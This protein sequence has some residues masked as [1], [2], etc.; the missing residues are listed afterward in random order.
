LKL[1]RLEQSAKARLDGEV[2][3]VPPQ[4]A[5][6]AVGARVEGQGL[7]FTPSR[8]RQGER[9]KQ[10]STRVTRHAFALWLGRRAGRQAGRQACMSHFQDLLSSPFDSFISTSCTVQYC[11]PV[12]YWTVPSS[13][14]PPPSSLPSPTQHHSLIVLS[15]ACIGFSLV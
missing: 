4:E 9:P 15:Q 5:H 1:A 13:L 11:T 14:L 3:A 2:V 12:P 6:L 7:P 8:T 10:D